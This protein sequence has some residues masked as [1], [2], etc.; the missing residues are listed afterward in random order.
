[1]RR[2]MAS[3][4]AWSPP[5]VPVR[6]DP[7]RLDPVRL[8]PLPDVVEVVTESPRIDVRAFW[9]MAGLLNFKVRTTVVSLVCV[10]A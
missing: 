6:L 3:E 7:V 8:L 9:I 4:D 5:P 1:M 2:R 10:P